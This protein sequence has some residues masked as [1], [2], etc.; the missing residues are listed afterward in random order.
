MSGRGR[1]RGRGRGKTIAESD[2]PT[3]R[4]SKKKQ[5][6]VVA[7]V[8]PNGI[9]GNLQPESR[10]PLIAHLPIQ[11]RDIMLHDAWFN[12]IPILPLMWNLMTQ[13]WTI[14]F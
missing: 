4:T 9:E 7:V 13:P 12:T 1:G 3:K 10:K 8:T 6:S 2:D 5:F 14:R 11:S